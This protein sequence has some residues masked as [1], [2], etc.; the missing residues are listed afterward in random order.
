M[1]AFQYN[2]SNGW[3]NFKFTH[4]H[5]VAWGNSKSKKKLAYKSNEHTS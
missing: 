2:P 5:L 1:D 3:V 4:W